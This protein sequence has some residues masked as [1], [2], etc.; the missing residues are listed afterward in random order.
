MAARR[1]AARHVARP[2]GRTRLS[3]WY[4]DA[5]EPVGE[6]WFEAPPLLVKFLFTSSV[7]SVQV[8]PPDDVARRRHNSAGKTEM[9]H[10]VEAEAGAAIAAGFRRAVTAEELRAAAADG[11]IAD[12][13]EWHAASPGDTFFIPAGVV[14]AIGAGLVLCEIQQFSD[15]TYRLYD[16]GRQPAR[17]LHLEESVA[18]ASLGPAQCRVAARRGELVRCPYFVTERLEVAGKVEWGGPSL[19]IALSGTGTVQEAAFHPGEV[20]QVDAG[21]MVESH[22]SVTALRVTIPD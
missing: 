18:V 1:L 12:L 21:G 15:V 22:E 10:V 5:L 7:L 4:P 2:W 3:P 19:L 9:W 8:H 20:W 17:E 6:V 13:M 16:W 14:H 11:S